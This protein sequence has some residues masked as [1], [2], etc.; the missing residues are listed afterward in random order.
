MLKWVGWGKNTQSIHR[1]DQPCLG[2]RTALT[3]RTPNLGSLAVVELAADVGRDP[4][5]LEEPAEVVNLGG[6]GETDGRTKVTGWTACL[7]TDDPLP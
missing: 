6:P 5:G 4:S 1:A 7:R 3:L 2:R